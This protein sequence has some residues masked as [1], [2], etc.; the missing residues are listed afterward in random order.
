MYARW[1]WDHCK[2]ITHGSHKSILSPLLHTPSFQLCLPSSL[3]Q[4][5]MSDCHTISARDVM[6][7]ILLTLI[8]FQHPLTDSFMVWNRRYWGTKKEN[9]ILCDNTFTVKAK[10]K[11]ISCAKIGW[12]SGLLIPILPLKRRLSFGNLLLKHRKIVRFWN[13][14]QMLEWNSLPFDWDVVS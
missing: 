6:D 2:L 10:T 13:V 14:S 5:L 1:P 8:N 7:V 4:G 9:S 11:S 12:D 3:L